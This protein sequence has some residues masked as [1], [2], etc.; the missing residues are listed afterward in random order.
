MISYRMAL[1]RAKAGKPN[2]NE[3]EYITK[4]VITWAD[5][6][7]EIELEV[8]NDGYSDDEFTAWIEENAEELARKDAAKQGTEFEELLNIDY[9]TEIYDDDAAFEEGYLRA[10]EDEGDYYREMGW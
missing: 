1:A 10:C 8:E 9:E 2:W 7:Y 4:A 5:A 6:E 3:E